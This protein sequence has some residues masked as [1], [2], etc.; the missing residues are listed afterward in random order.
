VNLLAHLKPSLKTFDVIPIFTYPYL[1]PLNIY[2]IY[3]LYLLLN[4][5]ERILKML[6]FNNVKSLGKKEI[7]IGLKECIIKWWPF[8]LSLKMEI[9]MQ[10]KKKGNIRK[11]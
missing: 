6:L 11:K 7:N 5:G 8:K 4:L 10:P 1:K 2:I 9:Q 3:F